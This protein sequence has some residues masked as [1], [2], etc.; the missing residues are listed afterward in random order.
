MTFYTVGSPSEMPLLLLPL[1]LCYC[2]LMSTSKLSSLPFYFKP[3]RLPHPTPLQ[4]FFSLNEQRITTDWFAAVTS[5]PSSYSTSTTTSNTSSH[6][7]VVCFTDCWLSPGLSDRGVLRDARFSSS[8]Q[9]AQL[10][11]HHCARRTC[12]RIRKSNS[13]PSS[14]TGGVRS[15]TTVL[16]PLSSPFAFYLPL[17][18]SL[19]W[20][21]AVAVMCM[22][23]TCMFS[24]WLLPCSLPPLD[25]AD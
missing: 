16:S 23:S 10:H 19:L 25:T 21:T 2:A 22:C 15:S 18:P 24:L 13:W 8:P 14:A 9:E 3:S 17:P 11:R 4:H 12:G 6:A 7:A 1:L 5:A 20:A